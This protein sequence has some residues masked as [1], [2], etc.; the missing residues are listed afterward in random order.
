MDKKQSFSMEERAQIVTLSNI[1]FSLGKIAKRMKVSKI[2]VHNA[3][4]KYQNKSIFI[5]RKVGISMSMP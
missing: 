3:I 2:A 5:D 1:K 4:I